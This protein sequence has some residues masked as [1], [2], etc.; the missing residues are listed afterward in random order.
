M[1]TSFAMYFAVLSL[2]VFKSPNSTCCIDIAITS[3]LFCPFAS[4][5]SFRSKTLLASFRTQLPPKLVI[6]VYED[7]RYVPL[8]PYRLPPIAMSLAYPRIAEFIIT[9]GCQRC[10]DN[11]VGSHGR[12]IAPSL[13]RIAHPLFETR[14]IGRFQFPLHRISTS[15]FVWFVHPVKGRYDRCC[16]TSGK[17]GYCSGKQGV[18][19]GL[20]YHIA[21]MSSLPSSPIICTVYV[22]M[23]L[24]KAP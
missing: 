4:N 24:K 2:Q 11:I 23:I 3:Y 9:A 14:T 15:A 5:L 12:G 22:S 10:L 13:E 19:H 16:S 6:W 21:S 7:V 18:R 17:E 20:T 8:T 1:S